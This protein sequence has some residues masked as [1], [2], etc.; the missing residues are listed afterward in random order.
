MSADGASTTISQTCHAVCVVAGQLVIT[1]HDGTISVWPADSD[2]AAI[3]LALS[4]TPTSVAITKFADH[5]YAFWFLDAGVITCNLMSQGC[6]VHTA[7]AHGFETAVLVSPVA[8][9]G[10]SVLVTHSGD[11]SPT[12]LSIAI[13]SVYLLTVPRMDLPHVARFGTNSMLVRGNRR[14]LLT[15]DTISHFVQ[16]PTS[17]GSAMLMSMSGEV[18]S[19]DV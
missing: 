16:Y 18:L 1:D 11:L 9:R 6:L 13:D 5:V 3:Q 7:S 12:Q 19:T 2:P 15:S 4:V 14:L 8:Q 17:T 10:D